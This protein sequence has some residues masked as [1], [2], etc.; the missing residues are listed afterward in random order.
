MADIIEFP[1]NPGYLNPAFLQQKYVVE[2]LSC[3]EIAAIIGS[4]RTTILK[5][6]KRFNI[7]IREAGS[8]INRRRGLA[9][10][11]KISKRSEEEHKRELE[12]INLYFS[13]RQK[14]LG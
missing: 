14:I 13:Y 11:Q 12:N 4:A 10:G 9:Y 3:E 6:L 8:N 1:V 2:G 7:P 5:Y